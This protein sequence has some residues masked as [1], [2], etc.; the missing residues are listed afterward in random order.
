MELSERILGSERILTA[1]Q[2][3]ALGRVQQEQRQ[4]HAG[5]LGAALRREECGAERWLPGEPLPLLHLG[6]LQGTK[7]GPSYKGQYTLNKVSTLRRKNTCQHSI[8]CIQ[9]SAH[10]I[11]VRVKEFSQIEHTHVT[12]IQVKTQN[13]ARTLGSRSQDPKDPNHC[14]SLQGKHYPNLQIGFARLY[15]S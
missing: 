12:G 14:C 3:R 2:A 11:C 15:T 6:L 4:R 8:I 7:E 13:V 1:G 9:Q 5:A 10:I